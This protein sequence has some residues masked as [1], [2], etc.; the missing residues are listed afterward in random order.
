[1]AP[2]ARSAPAEPAAGPGPPV[3]TPAAAGWAA[4]WRRTADG[5]EP[6]LARTG[7]RDARHIGAARSALGRAA[8]PPVRP[9]QGTL[10]T[11]GDT[12]PVPGRQGRT[13]SR[14]PKTAAGNR[15]G[16]SRPPKS[17]GRRRHTAARAPAAPGTTGRTCPP[18][19]SGSRCRICHR[20][21]HRHGPR[22][23]RAGQRPTRRRH[24]PL[25]CRRPPLRRCGPPHRHPRWL[26][27]PSP[28]PVWRDRRPPGRGRQPPRRRCRPRSSSPL[29]EPRTAGVPRS[30]PPGRPSPAIG[31]D[32]TS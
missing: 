21:T 13:G 2:A 15:R 20:R 25:R 11:G 17:A 12:R 16:H 26:L 22:R 7:S 19:T 27:R 14:Y 30:P 29:P 32:E 18:M 23:A 31:R 9:V 1:M 8:A 28:P 5:R 10:R 6:P 4:G 24:P 3:V